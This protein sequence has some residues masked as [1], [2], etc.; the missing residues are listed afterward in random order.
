VD[1]C[2]QQEFFP[3][4]GLFNASME[5]SDELA[6]QLD[7][8]RPVAVSTR[9]VP[10]WSR[11]ALP[12]LAKRG[13][14]GMSFGSGGPPGRPY[15]VPPLFVWRDV[16]SGTEMVVTSESGYGGP[17]TQFVLP[18]GV[19]LAVDWTGDNSGPS[20]NGARSGLAGLRAQFPGANVHASTFNAFFK[21]ANKPENKAKLPIVTAEVGDAW[22][23][24][25]PSDPLKCAQFRAAARLRDQCLASG[26]CARSSAAMKT[27]D[28]MLVKVPE[29]TWG[30]AQSWFLP[31]YTN[32][33][34]VD[35]SR[36]RAAVK[37]PVLDNRQQADYFTQEQSW[38][39]QRAF[40]TNAV[41]AVRGSIPAFASRLDAEFKAL[42]DV[43]VPSTEGYVRAQPNAPLNC[44]CAA[45][46]EFDTSG[47]SSLLQ[48]GNV[49]WANASHRL[50]RYIYQS[51]D[52]TDY[53]E[54]LAGSRDDSSGPGFGRP[55][56]TPNN[57]QAICGNFNKP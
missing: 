28:R 6:Q 18:N 12:L 32:W 43:R 16:A 2:C 8:E 34:N 50:G 24:G 54:F 39:E 9:D 55:M 33:S 36:A 7:V 25:V 30:L 4:V 26:E 42:S 45:I 49:S 10:F 47:A 21:E 22:I 51:F 17:G 57:T 35:F 3:N 41:D 48:R 29:H 31:D 19:A 38:H 23:Y 46:V 13:I 44:G 14:I 11:A 56:C 1:C 5:L 52:D 20:A 40:I 53:Q 27:F 15:G 37:A